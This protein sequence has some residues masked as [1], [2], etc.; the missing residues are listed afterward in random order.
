[1]NKFKTVAL[2]MYPEIATSGVITRKQAHDVFETHKHSGI[3][4]PQS[5]INK[6]NSVSRGVFNFSANFETD[7]TISLI[8]TVVE[9]DEELDTRISETYETLDTLVNSVAHNKVN[10][11]ILAGAAG[12][13]KSYE[14][15][16][17]LNQINHGEYGYIFH[18]GYLKATH[19]F[20]LLWENKENT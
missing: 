15:N 1:M 19:L 16:K 20:R 17:I 12:L 18:R 2:E 10:S 8:K 4:W 13:G 7:S 11:L 5:L 14:V 9:T 3:K 6:E